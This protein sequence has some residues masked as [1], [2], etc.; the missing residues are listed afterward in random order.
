MQ[1]GPW[2]R[3]ATT[4]SPYRIRRTCQRTKQQNSQAETTNNKP[5]QKGRGRKSKWRVCVCCWGRQS[6]A[7]LGHLRKLTWGEAYKNKRRT[8]RA[9]RD[10]QHKEAQTNTRKGQANKKRGSQQHQTGQEV[11]R[12]AE[13]TNKKGR[14]GRRQAEA[15][16]KGKRGRP[17]RQQGQEGENRTGQKAGA[18]SFSG[19]L[20][21]FW[22][23]QGR[24]PQCRSEGHNTSNTVE[25]AKPTQREAFI[26]MRRSEDRSQSATTRRTNGMTTGPCRYNQMLGGRDQQTLTG[27]EGAR[28][29]TTGWEGREQARRERAK[30]QQPRHQEQKRAKQPSRKHRTATTREKNPAA[31]REPQGKHRGKRTPDTRTTRAGSSR[32]E[33]ERHRPKHTTQNRTGREWNTRERRPTSREIRLKATRS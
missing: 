5:N 7:I 24:I 2:L 14:G 22:I 3:P 1:P 11:A 30:P 18:C 19:V 20:R 4:Y 17:G 25:R 9:D 6:S 15:S 13:P 8:G 21:A 16:R 33:A 28:G 23:T 26:A 31:P 32:W 27:P 12:R 10:K 29:P